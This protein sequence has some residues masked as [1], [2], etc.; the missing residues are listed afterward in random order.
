MV[1]PRSMQ[2][3]AQKSRQHK[4][5]ACFIFKGGAVISVANNTVASHAEVAALRK[6]KDA[7]NTILLSVR[8]GRS[9]NLRNAR[10]CTDCSHY[11][12]SRGI[13][14]VLYSTEEG[15]IKRESI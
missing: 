14:I 11:I 15:I 4:K 1:S 2:R 3:A 6:I 12:R 5:H 10:P 13:K 8:V 9:G 7:R